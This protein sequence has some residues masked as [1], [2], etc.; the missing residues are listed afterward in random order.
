MTK[1]NVS[2][3]FAQ[4][5]TEIW[6]KQILVNQDQTVISVIESSGF[7]QEFP[8]FSYNNIQYGVYGLIVS[9]DSIVKN[10]DRIEIYRDLVF[11][12]MQSRRRRAQLKQTTKKKRK[13]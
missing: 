13:K 7:F 4:S 9:G 5:P 10:N 3:V 12:P 6:Q 11:D 2:L 8:Y 1:I